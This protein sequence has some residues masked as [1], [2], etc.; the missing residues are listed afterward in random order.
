M[1]FK[2]SVVSALL[3]RVTQAMQ[4]YFNIHLSIENCFVYKYA[5]ILENF[6]KVLIRSFSFV[7]K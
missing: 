1:S 3:K 2:F 7:L 4:C 5:L 6:Y